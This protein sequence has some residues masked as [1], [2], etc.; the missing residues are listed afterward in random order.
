MKN[1]ETVYTKNYVEIDELLKNVTV[2][3]QTLE[4]V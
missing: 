1:V 3:F 2:F 4:S